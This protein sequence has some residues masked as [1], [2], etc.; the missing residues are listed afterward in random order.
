MQTRSTAD[1]PDGTVGQATT[2]LVQACDSAGNALT[3]GGTKVAVTITGANTSTPTVTDNHDGTFTAT[4]TPTQSGTDA[5][6]ITLN[7]TAIKASPYTSTVKPEEY[8]VVD[9]AQAGFKIVLA[10][11]SLT[12]DALGSITNAD[13]ASAKVDDEPAPDVQGNEYPLQLASN[14]ITDGKISTTQFGDIPVRSGGL[15]GAISM[16]MTD[17]QE[18]KIRE[19]LV[20]AFPADVKAAIAAGTMNTKADNGQTMLMKAA[21]R[22]DTESVKALIAAGADINTQDNSGWTALI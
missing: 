8:H 15:P 12:V 1:V 10:M 18:R 22:G 4:Y 17:S 9:P 2:I 5:V 3:S 7:G 21:S 19:F 13:I 16:M 14:A 6:A 20:K 11:T